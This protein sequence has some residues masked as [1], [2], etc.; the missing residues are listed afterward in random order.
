[1][2]LTDEQKRAI[3]TENRQIIAQLQERV[4]FI[5]PREKAKPSLSDIFRSDEPLRTGLE[6]LGVPGGLQK[7]AITAKGFVTFL[8]DL[9]KDIV[10]P[11]YKGV[12]KALYT[13]PTKGL[14]AAQR[15][16]EEE[17]RPHQRQAG[18]MAKAFGG[19]VLDWLKMSLLPDTP[20]G[21]VAKQRIGDRIKEH[22]Y[23]AEAVHPAVLLGLVK[24]GAKRLATKK[25]S[26][27]AERLGAIEKSEIGVPRKVIQDRLKGIPEPEPVRAEMLPTL[28]Q[29]LQL[30]K[31]AGP[32]PLLIPKKT[33]PT[34]ELPDF[35]LGKE[36]RLMRTTKKR[37]VKVSEKGVEL[38]PGERKGPLYDRLRAVEEMEPGISRTRLAERLK[39]IREGEIPAKRKLALQKKLKA[40]GV[41]EEPQITKHFQRYTSEQRASRAAS[42]RLG[43]RAKEAVG[44]YFYTNQRDNI[45]YKTA[46]EAREAFHAKKPTP[47]PAE[48]GRISEADLKTTAN[49]MLND[50]KYIKAPRVAK[51]TPAKGVQVDYSASAP[52]W[53]TRMRGGTG[54]GKAETLTG[55]RAIIKDGAATENVSGQRLLSYVEEWAQRKPGKGA[56]E[57]VAGEFKPGDKVRI[58]DEWYEAKLSDKTGEV[59][60]IDSQKIEMD[61][62]DKV[63]VDE[64]RPVKPT[65]KPPAGKPAGKVGIPGI[66]GVPLKGKLRADVEVLPG[67]EVLV[68]EAR[69]WGLDAFVQSVEST[70]KLGAGPS[71]T[72]GLSDFG[73]RIVAAMKILDKSTESPREFWRRVRVSEAEYPELGKKGRIGRAKTSL[74]AAEKKALDRIKKRGTRLTAGIDPAEMADL[75]IIGA[76]KIAKGTIKFG[77][78]SAEMVREYGAR[79]KPYLKTIYARSQQGASRLKVNAELD[80]FIDYFE[81]IQ[82]P[83]GLRP[84]RKPVRSAIRES[85][86]EEGLTGKELTAAANAEFIVEVNRYGVALRKTKGGKITPAIR[87]AGTYVPDDFATYGKFKDAKAGIFGGTK[88]ATRFIQEIDGALSVEAKAKLSGQGGPAERYVLHRTRDMVKSKLSWTNAMKSRLGTITKGSSKEQLRTANQVIE[89]ISRE[90]A[91]VD[92]A[93]LLTNPKISALTKDVRVV[94]LAQEG[95][96]LYESLLRHQNELRRLRGQTEIPHRDYYTAH[97]IHETT[98]WERAVGHNKTPKQTIGPGLPDYIKP[99]APFNARAMAREIGLPETVREMNLQTLLERYIETAGKDIYNTSI[100]QNNKAFIQQLGSMGYKHAARGLENWTAEAFGGVKGAVDRAANLSP[101]IH[102]GMSRFRQ[103]LIRSVFPLNFAWNTFVQTSSGVLTYARYGNRNSIRGLYDWFGSKKIRQEIRDNAYSAIIKSQ[104]SGRIS[105]Q[106]INRGVG[107]AQRLSRGKLEKV[108]DASNFFTEWVERHL[109]GWSVATAKRHGA[110][111]GLK[112]KAL[113]EYA[114]DGGAKT[115]SMYNLED[116][117]G[118]LR[119]ELVKTG[120]P[121]QTFS[122]EVFNTLREFAGKTG[123]P[124]A[125]AA[126]R[127]KQVLRFLAG[128]TAVNYIGQAA[129]GRKPWE[130]S[131]FIPFYG[132]FFAPVAA[133]LKGEDVSMTSTRGLPSPVGIT[134]KGGQAVHRG[135]LKPGVAATKEYIRTGDMNEALEEFMATGKW[136]KLRRFTI[137]YLSGF[138]GLP[139]G[140]QMNRVV[141]GLIA[142]SAGGMVDSAG[143]LMFPITDTKDKMRTFLAG[144]WASKGGQEYWD[145]RGKEI[146]LYIESLNETPLLRDVVE[147]LPVVSDLYKFGPDSPE[148]REFNTFFARSERKTKK[149]KELETKEEK[150]RYYQENKR[151]FQKVGEKPSGEKV[152][153]PQALRTIDRKISKHRKQIRDIESGTVMVDKKPVK[154]TDKQ[155]R[156]AISNLKQKIEVLAKAALK[157]RKL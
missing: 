149:L 69:S 155:K 37:K 95:R 117:P 64:Y 130:L 10:L 13:L 58:G 136:D 103:G 70:K 121:F 98:I 152:Y 91:Y 86:R 92:P 63:T 83:K 11:T 85:L 146:D 1:M 52:A 148:V 18:E 156:L 120:G 4:S 127:T 96:K 105:R 55:L 134:I 145:K 51:G 22:G 12:A 112:G 132:A 138:A 82:A 34:A 33:S 118:M 147:G 77:E 111:K 31:K 72:A 93:K 29:I 128:V 7:E 38:R 137:R 68:E 75:A 66:G 3:I 114:S 74:D 76:A 47:A 79:I 36:G 44:E 27:L 153:L 16:V 109:T 140:T 126:I 106:D 87:E 56:G 89:H 97:S 141:D 119:S 131:S 60:L 67:L 81:D 88:D 35:V 73:N 104:R 26:P 107:A 40:E 32:E 42:H 125:T 50:A 30:P 2:P 78:W 53:Y 62:F 150:A 5:G 99:N 124:P 143:K 139:G 20:A 113:W 8:P 61:V 154:L 108:S 65:P 19:G 135:I 9:A 59:K 94:R 80:S 15:V 54:M 100:I 142:V 102:K 84:P 115:Q 6:A 144:P 49:E 14:G 39:G 123:C 110:A 43:H 116:L 45:A 23:L 133:A 48:K 24:G 90:G 46:K 17:V 101:T 151:F 71:Y 157:L 122:F 57:M 28:E 25:P 41:G 129:I 21:I